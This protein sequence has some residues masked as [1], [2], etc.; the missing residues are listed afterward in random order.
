MDLADSQMT[1]RRYVIDALPAA[2]FVN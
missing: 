1:N 2:F